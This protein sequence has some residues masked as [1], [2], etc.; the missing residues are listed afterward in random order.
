M[1]LHRLFPAMFPAKDTEPAKSRNATLYLLRCVFFMGI[2]SPPKNFFLVYILWSFALNLCSTFYQPIGFISGFISHLSEFSPGDF[3]T[4]MQVTFNAYSCS[5]KVIIVWVLHKRF[6][7]ANLILDQMDKRLTQPKERS[8]VHS[9][10][11]FSNR[12][13]FGFMTVYMVYA[14]STFISAVSFGRPPY[15]NY[16]PFLDWRSSKWE[17]WLQA[18]LEYFAMLGACFQDVCVDCYPINFIL[19]LRAHMRNFAERLRQLGQDPNESPEESHEKLIECIQDHKVILRFCDTLRPVISGT[20]FVQLL[21]VGLVLGFTIINIVLFANFASRI[22][23]L[24]FMTAVLLE[25]T[26]FC[27]LC[28]YLTDDCFDLADALFESNWIDKEQR[29]KKTLIQFLQSLQKPIVFMAGNVFTI[30]VATNISATKFSFSVFTLVKQ[31]NIAEK[32]SQPSAI[33]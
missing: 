13:F 16:Y 17:F 11:S 3:L 28:N 14:T 5:T 20:I 30:S 2:Q 4:S 12:I 9:A 33:E 23:A 26:P 6:E 18:G 32:L 8:K 19:P 1:V 29:Y 22:A 24:S 21:V 7:K 10:V 15:Q 25:T 27:I 31:M